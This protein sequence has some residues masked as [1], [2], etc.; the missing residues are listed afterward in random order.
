MGFPFLF[1]VCATAMVAIM[2]VDVE[3]GR[4][5]ARRFVLARTRAA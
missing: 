5:D 4:A 3:K 2:F 1:A